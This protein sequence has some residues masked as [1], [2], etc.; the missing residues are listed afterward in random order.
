M[1]DLVIS[2]GVLAAFVL[3]VA[4]A[5]WWDARHEQHRAAQTKERASIARFHANA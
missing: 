5:G 2:L 1:M 3:I 4:F